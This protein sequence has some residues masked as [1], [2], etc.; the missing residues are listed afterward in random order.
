MLMANRLQMF[1]M[2]ECRGH[3]DRFCDAT[4]IYKNE[5][6]LS[7]ISGIAPWDPN[8]APHELVVKTDVTKWTELANKLSVFLLT[9]PLGD[10]ENTI[11]LQKLACDLADWSS[12]LSDAYPETR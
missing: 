10:N 12:A 11:G 4:Q 6:S 2:W 5:E 3:L 9:R 1:P 7:P 8:I